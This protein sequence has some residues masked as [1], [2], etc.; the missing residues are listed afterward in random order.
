LRMQLLAC[1]FQYCLESFN[2]D[3]PFKFVEHFHKTAHV[4]ALEMMRQIYVHVY[5]SIDGLCSPGA[6]KNNNRILDVFN[7][8]LFDVN[9]AGIFLILYVDHFARCLGRRLKTIRKNAVF[10]TLV[11]NLE[12][13][14]FLLEP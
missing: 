8:N 9:I 4:C 7:A 5:C 10:I 1:F 14:S 13:L 3:L 2:I 6:I 12:S 11:F